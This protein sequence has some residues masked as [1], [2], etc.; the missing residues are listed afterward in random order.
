MLPATLYALCSS[1]PPPMP[2]NAVIG[3][4][5]E[6]ATVRDLLT[7]EDNRIVTLTGPGG[8]GKTSLAL[9]VASELTGP[10]FDACAL[11]VALDVVRDPAHVL[12]AVA[13]ALGIPLHGDR[14]LRDRIAHELRDERLVLIADNMEHLLAAGPILAGLLPLCPGLSILATSRER[15]RVRGEIEVAVMPLPTPARL[16]MSGAQTTPDL[17]TLAATPSVQLFVDRMKDANPAFDLNPINAESVAEIC[18]RLDGIPLAL[19]LA[20]ARARVLPPGALLRRME[21]RLP[22]LTGGPRDQPQRLQTMRDAIAWSH[23]LLT[24]EEQA[25]FRRLSIF[26]GGFTLDAAETVAG[27]E[28]GKTARRQDGK[29]TTPPDAPLHRGGEGAGG[30]VFSHVSRLIS[31][32][33][34][35]D[36]V[37]SLVEKSLVRA[38]EQEVPSGTTEAEPRFAMLEMIREFGQDALEASGEN[39]A[40]RT[41]HAR[42]FAEQAEAAAPALAGPDRK[43]WLHRLETDDANLE[44]ALTW[45][46]AS[47]DAR[48]GL[49]LTGAL[50]EWFETTGQI[51]RGR[52]W[53]E[54]MLALPYIADP[55]DTDTA[56]ARGLTLHTASALAYRQSDYDAVM[57]FGAESFTI[58][59]SLG[60]TI[61]AARALHTLGNGAYSL[62]DVDA[63]IDYYTKGLARGRQVGH[64]PTMATALTNMALTLINQGETDRAAD[65]LAEALPITQAAG[66]T[67]RTANT[68]FALGRLA[69][70][71]GDAPRAVAR[72]EEALRL[73]RQIDQRSVP[74]TLRRLADAREQTGD[75]AQAAAAL[76]ESLLLFRERGEWTEAKTTILQIAGLAERA[77]QRGPAARLSN[78]AEVSPSQELAITQTSDY[79]HAAVFALADEVLTSLTDVSATAPAAPAP[80]GLTPREIEVL[81][82]V[83]EGKTDREIADAL[84]IS[85]NTVIRHVA[86]ILMKLDVNSRTAAAS[87][88]LRNSIV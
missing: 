59:E 13:A 69:R 54:R 88:A 49:R 8:V 58:A 61:P 40:T 3:R 74:E 77:G 73:R 82:L 80:G 47:G 23:E 34:V 1:T 5:R 6:I 11:F 63:A 76:R 4:D 85:R 22:L 30:E 41:R 51:D 60:E 19:E 35:L 68:I 24:P 70:R 83:A 66:D 81:R 65:L 75:Y 20:A 55:A 79:D 72:F 50:R 78:L 25:V 46:E 53:A 62:G 48:T 28:D 16:T 56:R 52:T 45:A 17:A 84:F 26:T 37:A 36:L 39:A 9:A 67:F 32:V 29:E 87:F 7:G 2:P 43:L 10:P 42:W 57:R 64:A 38:M 33:S 44:A 21:R 31:H 18:R 12:T 15:L 86:N 71:Q 27:D 14:T